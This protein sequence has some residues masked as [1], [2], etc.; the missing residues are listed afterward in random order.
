MAVTS[1]DVGPRTTEMLSSTVRIAMADYSP[2][3]GDPL[4]FAAEA[5]AGAVGGKVS[6][7][8][9]ISSKAGVVY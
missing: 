3:F 7:K 2:A 8:A 1:R 6:A 4:M 5:L 9:D